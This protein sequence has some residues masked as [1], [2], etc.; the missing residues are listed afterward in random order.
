MGFLDVL[1][2]LKKIVEVAREFTKDESYHIID[3]IKQH[4]ESR[5]ATE[6]HLERIRLQNG[7][8]DVYGTAYRGRKEVDSDS[9]TVDLD[10]EDIKV[11]FNKQKTIVWDLR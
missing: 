10:K 8:W 9:W 4:Q 3:W 7:Q 6:I 5:D 2:G 11:L 1:D